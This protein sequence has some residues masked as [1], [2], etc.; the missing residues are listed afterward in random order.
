MISSISYLTNDDIGLI[1]FVLDILAK[2]LLFLLIFKDIIRRVGK[3]LSH[4]SLHMAWVG[5]LIIIGLLPVLPLLVQSFTELDWRFSAIT[6]L[7]SY[8]EITDAAA[9]TSM[10]SVSA[11]LISFYVMGVAIFL[12]RLL[13]SFIKLAQIR[14]SA[15]YPS[16]A[17]DQRLLQGIREQ[18][19]LKAS[20][21]LGITT[22][23][24]SPVSFGWLGPVVL[25][26]ESWYEWSDTTKLCVLLHE[27]T[28]IK[29]IDWL[30]HI[31]AMFVTSLNWF[32]P[33]I[34]YSRTQI[35]RCAENACDA[36]VVRTGIEKVDYADQLL[37]FARNRKGFKSSIPLAN[38]MI[39]VS[40]LT[41]RVDAIL[42]DDRLSSSK[43][44][45][46]L[47][48][49]LLLTLM[50]LASIRVLSVESE[51]YYLDPVLVHSERVLY[52]SPPLMH[53]SQGRTRLR[54]NID[55]YGNVE[56]QSIRIISSTDPDALAP[57][58][59][60]ALKKFKYQPR[61]VRGVPKPTRGLESEFTIRLNQAGF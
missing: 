13:F 36:M 58:A 47:L 43:A 32:N 25:V 9:A 3:K 5:F 30:T 49:L 56:A 61:I 55:E 28:H 22:H 38:H 23:T 44:V 24:K 15:V 4:A 31:L 17:S 37:Q 52:R 33:V 46:F 39:S 21:S 27:L 53:R 41:D 6:F 54:F 18:Y 60:E 20:P 57:P 14:H 48:T 29:R 16:H 51:G 45:N 2:S 40:E 8:D 50:S 11:V 26:P 42:E 19:D 7:L 1:V 34:W 59:I 35:N 10:T 12:T